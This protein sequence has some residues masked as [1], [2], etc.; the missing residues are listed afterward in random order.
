MKIFKSAWGRQSVLV[1]ARRQQ[2]ILHT[3]YYYKLNRITE[4]YNKEQNQNS[5]LGNVK[6]KPEKNE[7]LTN[8][9]KILTRAASNSIP[10]L[11]NSVASWKE[12]SL[13]NK[14]TLPELNIF[15]K[16]FNIE[17]KYSDE[18]NNNNVQSPQNRTY[19]P[20]PIYGMPHKKR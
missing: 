9:K 11:D 5:S 6:K 16:L 15:T 3:N 19:G 12:Y 10:E 17:K 7:I 4:N 18:N 1:A 13:S 14:E 20:Y 8:N 2:V